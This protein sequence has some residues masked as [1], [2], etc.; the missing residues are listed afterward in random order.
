MARV[1]QKADVNFAILGPEEVCNG[2]MARRAGNEYIAQILMM[3]NIEVFD[4]YKPKKILTGCPHCYNIIK[5]EYP[6]FGAS[7]E[8]VHHTELLLEL[9]HQGRLKT[10]NGKM[11]AM[12]FHD[13][14]YLGR[15][16]GI[17]QAPRD[18]LSMITD[19]AKP[20]EMPRSESKGFCCGAGGARMFMEETIGKR[21]NEERAEEIIAAGAK[22]VAVACPFCTTMLR[23]GIL[24]KGSD[25]QVKDIV[26]I[27]DEA[28]S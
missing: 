13:S 10:S 26:E 2:D 19:G 7:Y 25:V 20:I 3:Q 5:N 22:T 21:I 9:F 24:E 16:N 11:E 27:I 1:L 23:D 15:W 12:T 18:L 28:I 17:Y 8:V 14:C 4:Q 6:Q